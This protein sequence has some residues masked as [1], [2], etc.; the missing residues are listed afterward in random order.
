MPLATDDRHTQALIAAQ[1]SLDLLGILYREHADRVD[2]MTPEL[3]DSIPGMLATQRMHR[4]DDAG[5][6]LASAVT[7]IQRLGQ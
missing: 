1:K 5:L 6:H 4:L 3:A 7:F 2:A